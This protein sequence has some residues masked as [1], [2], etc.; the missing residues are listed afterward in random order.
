MKKR[1]KYTLV[2]LGSLVVLA[3]IG[4]EIM[5]MVSV[6]LPLSYNHVDIF[7]CSLLF[8]SFQIPIHHG[9]D[10]GIRPYILCRLYHVDNGID[11]QDDAHDADRSIDTGHQR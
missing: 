9:A 2:S 4:L 6:F 10:T 8:L 11:W 5:Y 3:G 1:L 7:A